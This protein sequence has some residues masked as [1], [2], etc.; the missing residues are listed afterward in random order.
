MNEA[1]TCAEED[2]IIFLFSTRCDS[3]ILW[4]IRSIDLVRNVVSVGSIV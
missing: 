3:F 2:Y 1:V 4:R